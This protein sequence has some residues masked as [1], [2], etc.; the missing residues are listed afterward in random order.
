MGG[1]ESGFAAG[2][3]PML[4]LFH[5]LFTQQML[6]LNDWNQG[7]VAGVFAR[8]VLGLVETRGSTFW[9]WP[10]APCCADKETEAQGGGS[11]PGHTA[12]QAEPCWHL[13]LPLYQALLS[14]E[15]ES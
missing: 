1:Q 9:T 2:S 5:Q 4:N 15:N 12:L 14:P 8:E 11:L 10:Q 6:W 7:W 13:A 3:W